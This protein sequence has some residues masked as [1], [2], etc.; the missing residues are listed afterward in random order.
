MAPRKGMPCLFACMQRLRKKRSP[1]DIVGE[2]LQTAEDGANKTHI[3]YKV[4]LNSRQNKEY[5]NALRKAGFITENSSV[6]KTTEKGLHVLEACKL[7]RHL[8]EVA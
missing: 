7:C 5:L 3:M 2:I 4:G 6:W 1:H 8:C